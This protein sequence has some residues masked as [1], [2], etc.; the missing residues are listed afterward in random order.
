MLI[1]MEMVCEFMPKRWLAV[2]W[3]SRVTASGGDKAVQS[4]EGWLRWCEGLGNGGAV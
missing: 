1:Q 3:Y 4:Y 2:S